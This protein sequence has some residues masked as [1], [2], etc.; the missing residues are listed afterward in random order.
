MHGWLLAGQASADPPPLQGVAL[1]LLVR[2][3]RAE[4]RR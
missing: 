1:L 2:D 3:G 4:P